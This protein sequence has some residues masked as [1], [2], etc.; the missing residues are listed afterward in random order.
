MKDLIKNFVIYGLGTAIGKF[1]SV[2]LLPIYTAYFSPED[3]GNLELILTC[4]SILGAFGM[5]Q[6]ETSFQRFFYEYVSEEKKTL[7][8]TA[9]VATLFFSIIFV[10]VGSCLAPLITHWLKIEDF[11]W[12]LILSFV[13]VIPTNIVII[14]F[15]IF[16]FSEKPKMFT[17]L[18][19]TNILLSI[20]LTILFVL[21]F[22]LNIKGVIYATLL[23][24]GVVML[25]SLY[26]CR[27]CFSRKWDLKQAKQMLA[28]GLPQFPARLGSLSNSYINRFFIV[29]K[30][31]VYTLGLFSLGLRIASMMLMVQTAMQLAWL[32]YMYKLIKTEDNHKEILRNHVVR[33]IRAIL[34]LCALVA[35]FSKEIVLLLSNADY[36]EAYKV[37]GVISLS[38]ALYIFKDLV[39]IGVNI[40]KKTEYTSYIFFI[41]TFLNIL[42]IYMVPQ[43]WGILG[44]SIAMMA[45]NLILFAL[46][47]W[48]SERLYRIGYS[49][50]QLVVIIFATIAFTVLLAIYDVSI[51]VKLFVALPLIFVWGV[52]ER[53]SINMAY[54]AIRNKMSGAKDPPTF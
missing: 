23:A 54:K 44:I 32:P 36:L 9:L 47:L 8:T 39:D 4:T 13:T 16:R 5:L 1:I 45:S 11:T 19:L 52:S 6:I 21:V 14:L 38:Y 12:L 50:P 7:C 18:N 20:S 2:F 49:I 25:I 35:L 17:I 51:W 41:A 31:S 24:S 10:I 3:Y 37:V 53:D 22:D 43:S 26:L 30:F 48:V 34:L 15:V 27:D 40:K 28:F 46:T 29:G 42:F 33:L